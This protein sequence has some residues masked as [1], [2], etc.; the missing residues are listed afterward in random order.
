[1]DTALSMA[2]KIVALSTPINEKALNKLASMLVRHEF[3]K[4]EM[5]L[6][7]GQVSTQI[8]FVYKGLIRQFYY[9]NHKD[10]T[11]HM[12]IDGRMFFCIES[13]L[14]Q[15]PAYLLVEALEN[16]IVYGLPHDPFLQLCDEDH[17]VEMMYRYLLEDSLILSQYKA[18]F[19]RF[20]TANER[21][22]RLLREYPEI[23]QRA[24]LA[25]IASFLQMTPE[26]LSRVRA[27]LQL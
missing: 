22:A 1:M 14:R 15:R 26:T 11:E 10:V 25:H 20:E 23:I 17:D 2:K 12:A 7:E 3:K 19:I 21:Y 5:L 24:P 8:G 16:S 6:S 4:G 13:F 27:S 9:K 18:D